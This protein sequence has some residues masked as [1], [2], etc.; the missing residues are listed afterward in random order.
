MF[1]GRVVIVCYPSRSAASVQLFLAAGPDTSAIARRYCD[2][3]VSSPVCALAHEHGWDRCDR[4]WADRALRVVLRLPVLTR[5]MCS[6]GSNECTRRTLDHSC[7]DFQYQCHHTREHRY[8]RPNTRTRQVWPLNDG[9]PVR[10]PRV[11]SSQTFRLRSWAA[12][13][14][15]V[16]SQ[17]PD[18]R[19]RLLPASSRDSGGRAVTTPATPR[20]GMS[21]RGRTIGTIRFPCDTDGGTR[22][23]AAGT[24]SSLRLPQVRYFSQA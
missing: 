4:L 12:R 21:S 8:L 14:R 22:D 5:F 17:A 19:S 1:A 11:M 15:V 10:Y 16:P 7:R 2:A 9:L 23:E 3:R 24:G 20:S 18:V 6:T 13:L